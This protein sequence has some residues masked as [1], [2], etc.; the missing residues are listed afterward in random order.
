MP[1]GKKTSPEV[2]YEIMTSWAITNSYKET[3]RKLGLS[4][5]T[6]KDIVCRNKGK[7]EFVKLRTEKM[8][9]FS[10]KAS[11]IIGKGLTLL[12]KRFD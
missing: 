3:A 8:N 2:V 11:E 7:P 1:R 5:T 4:D 9:E 10:E 12:N 6:V